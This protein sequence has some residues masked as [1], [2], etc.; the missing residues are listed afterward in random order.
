MSDLWIYEWNWIMDSE[1]LPVNDAPLT[2]NEQV[3]LL[4]LNHERM[5]TLCYCNKVQVTSSKT[6][7][8]II[9]NDKSRLSL[10]FFSKTSSSCLH[11]QGEELFWI[12]FTFLQLKLKFWKMYPECTRYIFF[13]PKRILRHPNLQKPISGRCRTKPKWIMDYD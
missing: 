5:Y 9:F 11:H 3:L 6:V 7:C 4:Q 8:I 1:E 10:F 12:V 2:V 13:K